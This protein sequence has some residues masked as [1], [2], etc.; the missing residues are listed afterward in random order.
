MMVVIMNST[1]QTTEKDITILK[2]V[3]DKFGSKGYVRYDQ[4]SRVI[5]IDLGSKEKE[6]LRNEEQWIHFCDVE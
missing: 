1:T 3:R 5:T 4:P 2:S 6:L